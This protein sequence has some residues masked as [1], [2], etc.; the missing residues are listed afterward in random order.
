[1]AKLIPFCNRLRDELKAQSAEIVT[2]QTRLKDSQ[3]N[4]SDFQSNQLPT[5]YELTKTLHEKDLLVEQVK[6]LE[7]EVQ[8]KTR[9]ERTLRA[10]AS[11]KTHEL[12]TA[13]S[14]A[15]AELEE[16]QKQVAALKVRREEI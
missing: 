5:Q 14:R 7:Q 15:T 12:E 8:K 10:E 1:M 4:L 11:N 6:Y 3:V 2:L 9:E 16:A 13:L